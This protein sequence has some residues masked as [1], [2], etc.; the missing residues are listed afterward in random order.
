VNKHP[1]PL[2]WSKFL[3]PWQQNIFVEFPF[4]DTTFFIGS[5][6]FFSSSVFI[7]AKFAG[8]LSEYI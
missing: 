3:E 2:F 8:V 7:S 5:T 4:S 1:L 6:L